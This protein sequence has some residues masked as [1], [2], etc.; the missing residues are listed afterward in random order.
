M[1]RNLLLVTASIL[2][3]ANAACADVPSVVADIPPVHS[4]VAM[5]MEGVGSPDLLVAPGASPHGYSLKPSEARALE[6]ADVVFWVSEG[7]SPWLKGALASLADDTSVVE[8]ME[9][10]GTTELPFREGATFEKHGHGDDEHHGEQGGDSHAEGEEHHG[11]VVQ[12]EAEGEDHGHEKPGHDDHGDHSGNDPHGWLDP[13][14]GRVWLDVIAAELSKLDPE[15]AAIYS[16]NVEAGKAELEA[17][18]DH[19]MTD[20]LPVRGKPFIVFHDAYQYFENRFGIWAAGSIKLGDATEPSAARIKD[21]HQKVRELSIA[22]VFSEPQF[23]PGLVET[24]FGGSEA[25]T[26]M[27]D[28]LGTELELGLDLYPQLIRNVG[29]GLAD[30]LE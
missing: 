1:R 13:E 17:A 15:N 2:A 16:A 25:R 3:F 9:V 30:C 11:E 28:P 29:T 23:N 4:L 19:V 22:C 20:L 8:L 21:V 12:T 24:V 26:G 18:I 5:V 10:A 6:N 7:L 14:N 27:L